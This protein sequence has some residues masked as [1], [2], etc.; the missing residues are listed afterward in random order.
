MSANHL[1]PE[2]HALISRYREKWQHIGLSTERINQQHA[3]DAVRAIYTV[4]RL[5]EPEIIIVDSPN[6]AFEYIWN[7][8]Q[9]GSH[10]ILGDAIDS[11]YWS[12]IYSNLQSELL[13]R[14]PVNLQ[15]NLHSLFDNHL[16]KEY[17]TLLQKHLEN[18]WKQVFSQHLGKG[19]RNLLKNIFSSCRKPESLIAGGSYFDFCIYGLNY[20]QFKNK[21]VILEEFVKNCG[22]TFFFKNIAIISNHSTTISIDSNNHLHTEDTPAIAFADGYSLY[23]QHGKTRLERTRQPIDDIGWARFLEK[24]NAVEIDSWEEYRLLRIVKQQINVQTMQFLKATNPNTGE[25]R[26]SRVPL[27]IASAIEAV[28][29][30][31]QRTKP[32]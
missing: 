26:V 23:A 18:Q 19:D 25:V 16:A 8:L 21:V 15:T 7:L 12:R 1:T 31:N 27:R 5:N 29:W 4:L 28:H 24:I 13:V 2:Q 22:W 10:T 32:K 11:S 14:L 9:V 3:K 6:A 17:A 30:I 20:H